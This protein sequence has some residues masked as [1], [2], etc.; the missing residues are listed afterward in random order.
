MTLALGVTKW[1]ALSCE[2]CTFEFQYIPFHCSIQSLF[3]NV[4]KNHL[5][6][7]LLNKALSL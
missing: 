7:G 3:G 2:A 6:R 5:E 4:M 1:A